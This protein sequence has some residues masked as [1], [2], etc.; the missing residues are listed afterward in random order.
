MA[1]KNT[2]RKYFKSRHVEK[3][4]SPTGMTARKAKARQQ[5][6]RGFFAAL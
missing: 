2:V 6:M 3:V 1:Y 5:Q 4:S